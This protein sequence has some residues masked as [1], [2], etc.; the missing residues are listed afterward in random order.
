MGGRGK[1]KGE[2]SVPLALILQFDHWIRTSCMRPAATICPRPGLQR[3]RAAAALSQ[4]GRAGP[5]QPI[6]AIQPVGCT[7]RPPPGHIRQTSERQT[8]DVRQH[9]RLMPPGRGHNKILHHLRLTRCSSCRRSATK[10]DQPTRQK[11]FSLS[12]TIL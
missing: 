5:D 10:L 12:S 1:G 6:R 11:L 3:K 4:A 7:R 9:H 2:E 8:S